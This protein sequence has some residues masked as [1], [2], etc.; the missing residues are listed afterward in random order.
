MP[1]P[2]IPLVRQHTIR[3]S[4]L[5]FGAT[6]LTRHFNGY[7]VSYYLGFEVFTTV[8]MKSIIFWNMMPCSPLSFNRRFGG[9][10]RLHLQ[11]RR[12]RFSKISKQAGG[13]Q[14]VTI[15]Y[16]F[17]CVTASSVSVSTGWTT[18]GSISG[19]GG[20]FSLRHGVQTNSDV[21]SS[22]LRNVYRGLFPRG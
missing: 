22:F 5:K 8:V 15:V 9:T 10:Y 12:N 20:D 2:A 3:Y 16:Y 4:I 6:S 17:V 1:S 21:H 7:R 14:K 18:S 11:G 13:K 19:D